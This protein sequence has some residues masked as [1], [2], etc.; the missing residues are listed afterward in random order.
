[1]A[2]GGLKPKVVPFQVTLHGSA[3]SFQGIHGKRNRKAEGSDGHRFHSVVAAFRNCPDFFWSFQLRQ[4]LS[5]S[6]DRGKSNPAKKQKNKPA[7]GFH[8]DGYLPLAK[9]A[10]PR[11]LPSGA[12]LKWIT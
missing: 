1:M 8:G 5:V 9:C 7:R 6:P 11:C 2:G 12:R 10:N 4:I 3:L